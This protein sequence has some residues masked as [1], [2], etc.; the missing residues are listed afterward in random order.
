LGACF[1]WFG[2]IKNQFVQHSL[3]LVEQN[4]KFACDLMEG[5]EQEWVEEFVG[6]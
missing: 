4:K 1:L 2:L 6:E 3:E 5:H